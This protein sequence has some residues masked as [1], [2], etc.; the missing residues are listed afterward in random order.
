MTGE[1]RGEPARGAAI[2]PPKRYSNR[3]FP[4]YRYLP[5]RSPHPTR[6]PQG[7]SHGMPAHAV[8]S[9]SETDWPDCEEFLYGVDLFNHGYWWEA[10]EA[11]EGCWK[12]AGRN[13]DI[14]RFL[15]ALIQ[16]AAACLKKHL[17]QTQGMR[18]LAGDA[19]E[20]LP[21]ADGCRLG[22]PVPDLRIQVQSALLEGGMEYPLIR[23]EGS[24]IGAESGKR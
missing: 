13:S 5:G 14:G 6:D 24:G 17:G 3:P 1:H 9:F 18:L 20:K 15:Q 12:A 8:P 2:L 10:H 21:A 22:I 16:I 23:L 11:W 4:A 19:L 7:H